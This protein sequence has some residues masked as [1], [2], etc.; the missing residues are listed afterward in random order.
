MDSNAIVVEVFFG[1]AL[2]TVILL[3]QNNGFDQ[4][5]FF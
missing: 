2:Q 1:A 3:S 4:S 5:G